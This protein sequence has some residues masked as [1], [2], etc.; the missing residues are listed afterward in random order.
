M[1]YLAVDYGTKRVGLATGEDDGFGAYPLTTL[2]RSRSLPHDLGEIARLAGKETVNALVVG[3]P[4]NADGSL[5]PSAEAAIR[6]ARALAKRTPLPVY[7]HDEFLTTAEAE[8]EL[9]AADVSRRKRREVIDRMAAVHLLESFLRT[10][11]ESAHL[12]LRLATEKVPG[13]SRDT[14]EQKDPAA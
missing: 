4:I 10:R 5:G 11:R 7:L 9:I 8:E 1:R 2:V 12:P 3:L 6:F 13:E 14:V